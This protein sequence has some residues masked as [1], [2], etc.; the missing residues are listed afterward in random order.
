MPDH[1][2]AKEARLQALRD[3]YSA[4]VGERLV[5]IVHCWAQIQHAPGTSKEHHRGQHRHVHS[6]AADS[7]LY[8][9]EHSG[10]NRVCST[11]VV[12]YDPHHAGYGS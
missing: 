6:Q 3:A 1:K 4:G 5:N 11:E 10:R 2:Q 8:E 12:S 9:A 7:A